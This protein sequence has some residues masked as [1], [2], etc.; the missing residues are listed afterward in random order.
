MSD[1]NLQQVSREG[2]LK[3]IFVPR[4][5]FAGGHYGLVDLEQAELRVAA[6][7]SNDEAL[8]EALLSE[9]THRYIASRLL[10]KPMD[11][12]TPTE[13]KASKK[14]TFGVLYGGSAPGIAGK[15]DLPVELIVEIMQMLGREFKALAKWMRQ[16]KREAQETGW[17]STLFGRQRDVTDLR[18]RGDFGAIGRQAVNTPIQSLASDSMLVI[19]RAFDRGLRREKLH[20]RILWTIHDSTITEVYPGEEE[21]VARM[22]QEAFE[23]LNDTPLAKLP[24]SDRLPLTGS[25]LIAKSWAQVESTNEHY[26]PGP[27]WNCSSHGHFEAGQVVKEEKEDADDW[28]EDTDEAA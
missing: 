1:P 20:S 23:S 7:L 2:P 27:S 10:G 24:L 3:L 19:A 4:P 11:Q 21:A 9:D 5:E 6:L 13:R 18:K 17:I 12:I 16:R 8:V 14:V 28:E 15:A 26:E 25:F 22:A